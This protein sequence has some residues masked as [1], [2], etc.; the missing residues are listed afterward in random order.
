MEGK[1]TKYLIIAL[2]AAILGIELYKLWKSQN[3]RRE[4]L[5]GRSADEI[6]EWERKYCATSDEYRRGKLAR[7]IQRYDPSWQPPC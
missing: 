5:E 6:P 4:N 3:R 7:K 2:L 1:K